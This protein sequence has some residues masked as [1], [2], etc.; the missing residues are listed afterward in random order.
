MFKKPFQVKANTPVKKSFIRK[1]RSSVLE[2]FAGM[3]SEQVEMVLPK[4]EEIT[5]L[6]ILTRKE[7]HVV[8]YVVDGIPAFFECEKVLYP[9]VY[10]LWKCPNL[11]PCFTTWPSVLEKL[12]GGAA[13][14]LPG[15]D[16]PPEGLPQVEKSQL[17]AVNL[18]DNL[19]PVAIGTAAMSSSDMA[20]VTKGKAVLILHCFGDCLWEA[21]D[22]SVP[23]QINP[24]DISQFGAETNGENDTNG[25]IGGDNQAESEQKT[26][27]EGAETKGPTYCGENLRNGEVKENGV[28]EE[29]S[30]LLVP[31]SNGAVGGF[32]ERAQGEEEE[33]ENYGLSPTDMDH[34]LYKCFLHSL[35]EKVKPSDLPLLTSSFY[36]NYILPCCP[37]GKTLDIKKSN[38]KKV[39]TF[40][41]AMQEKGFLDIRN[42]TDGVDNVIAIYRNHDDIK[43]LVPTENSSETPESAAGSSKQTLGS[44]A[45]EGPPEFRMWYRVTSNVAPMLQS[46]G[47]QKGTWMTNK[48]VR[49]AVTNYVKNKSLVDQE[50]QGQVILDQILKDAIIDESEE[51]VTLL[52]WK[53]LFTRFLHKMNSGYEIVYPGLPASSSPR[54]HEGQV[55]PI[56]LKVK[57]KAGRKWITLISNL[58]QFNVDPKEFAH[59]LKIKIKASTTVKESENAKE[60]LR[61]TVQGNQIKFLKH[62][63]TDQYKIPKRY[64]EEL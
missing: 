29:M 23:P 24:K 3:T 47:F 25:I 27:T 42:A 12:R 55:Q 16:V 30:S 9:T 45:P 48:E 17:C 22:M 20:S 60:G 18:V 41:E 53:Q 32:E 14:M 2:K 40:L 50:N 39:S 5:A 13:L 19:T 15:V 31:C 57:T 33:G 64:I 46:S 6:K 21:G 1:L 62:F 26:T 58:Q 51:S 63:L 54:I 4:K 34:L 61:V 56:K 49:D 59:R 43:S 52:K 7:D 10:T 28:A 11:L 35:K 44:K 36:R 8:V 37:K 38:Y